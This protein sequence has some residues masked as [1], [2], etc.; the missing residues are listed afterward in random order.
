MKNVTKFKI[1]RS[2][3]DVY[4]AFVDPTKICNFW[5]SG[6]SCRWESG[7]TVTLE[8]VEYGAPGF[9]IKILE[10]VPAKKIIFVWGEEGLENTVTI[11]FAEF[12]MGNTIIEVIETGFSESDP[13]L[14]AKLVGNK[15][16]WV[17]MLTCLKAYMENGVNTLRVGLV[18]EIYGN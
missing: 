5:F 7:K 8:F 10:A 9:D 4:E 2:T 18:H 17:Y 11:L 15:E 16:G 14:T 3:T 1:L 12:E 13:D 6:S